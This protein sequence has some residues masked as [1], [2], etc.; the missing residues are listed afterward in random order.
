MIWRLAPIDA[1]IAATAIVHGLAVV[2]RNT[3]DFARSCALAGA[4]P[5]V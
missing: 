5:S 1:V 3:P 4:R 2:T